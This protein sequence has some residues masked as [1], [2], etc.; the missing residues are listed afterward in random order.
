M[1]Y[2]PVL[3]P[4]AFCFCN[5]LRDCINYYDQLTKGTADCFSQNE[6]GAYDAIIRHRCSTNPAEIVMIHDSSI[7]WNPYDS[8]GLMLCDS[9]PEEVISSYKV[10]NA[11]RVDI[12]SCRLK[13]SYDYRYFTAAAGA[14]LAG[15]SDAGDNFWPN[16]Y[17]R[18]P[19]SQNGILYFS[20]VAFN[21]DSSR[22]M[23]G[24]AWRYGNL[25]ADM[26]YVSLR[27][28]SGIWHVT[29][30]LITAVS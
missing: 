29:Y 30:Y 4:L 7:T 13:I 17:D 18:Y 26:G 16:F 9:F 23:V 24:I 21:A 28:E 2:L 15:A 5:D 19:E 10:I 1:K 25:G 12:G 27:K 14:E 11:Y 8:T 6:N 22:A 20:K 3:L